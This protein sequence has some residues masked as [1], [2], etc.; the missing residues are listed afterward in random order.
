MSDVT[1]LFPTRLALLEAAARGDLGALDVARTLL[2]APW[3]WPVD[4]GERALAKRCAIAEPPARPPGHAL[5]VAVDRHDIAAALWELVP[6]GIDQGRLA[7]HEN[8][9]GS[10]GN[11]KIVAARELSIAPS[12]AAIGADPTASAAPI[13]PSH[14]GAVLGGASFGLAMV[15]GAASALIG[16]PVPEDA[17]ATG[18]LVLDGSASVRRVGGVGRKAAMISRWAPRIRRFFVPTA[19]VAAARAEARDDLEIIGVDAPAE[20][21]AAVFPRSRLEGHFDAI[22]RD[23]ALAART[24]HQLFKLALRGDAKVH[25]G[26]SR[27]QAIVRWRPIAAAA[28]LLK[29]RVEDPGLRRLA[30]WTEQIALRHDGERAPIEWPADLAI[31]VR[32]REVRLEILAHIVQ[33]HADSEAPLEEIERTGNRALSEVRERDERGEGDTK[34]M[35]A[36]ARAFAAAGA[37]RKAVSAAAAAVSQWRELGRLAEMSR[38]LCEE[39]RVMAILGDRAGVERV[40]RD[41]VEAFRQSHDSDS[42][43]IAFVQLAV[44]RALTVLGEPR[45]AQAA[46]TLASVDWARSPEHLHASRARWLARAYDGLGLPDKAD[47]WRAKTT[48]DFALL[49]ALDRARARGTDDDVA[50]TVATIAASAESHLLQRM[51]R[52]GADA[53][54]LADEFAY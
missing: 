36:I 29:E 1:K 3:C 49:A 19:N 31:H 30:T 18:E 35:G 2:A 38:A 13:F 54:A 37:Y 25:I 41:D 46:L 16:L 22:W 47:E 26:S 27:L 48:K 14:D 6:E 43:S 17:C 42:N 40:L 28:G 20:V 15:L 12:V 50:V 39:L 9:V 53:R 51:V 21:V 45:R 11:A 32:S 7:F 24:T 33:S 34:L 10:V 52:R 8:A 44:G 5:L 23:E 4:A